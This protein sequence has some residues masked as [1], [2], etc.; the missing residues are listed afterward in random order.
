MSILKRSADL[1]YT[2]RFIKLMATKWE[3]LDAFK[4]G[5]IDKEGKRI[6]DKKLETSD[7]KSAYTPFL[8]LVYNI[9]RLVGKVPGGKSFVG[10]LAAALLL[11]KE[12]YGVK[13]KHINKILERLGIE[14]LDFLQE[15]SEWFVTQDRMLSP[16]VYRMLNES[17]LSDNYESLVNRGDQVRVEMDCYPVGDM[18]GLDVYEVTHVRTSKKVYLT[19]AELLK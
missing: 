13:E 6:K 19:A 1:V 4:L 12:D 10:S 18:F 8:R 9:K 16:G 5:I 3:N 11:I 7:E 15:S 14:T 17:I 2:L